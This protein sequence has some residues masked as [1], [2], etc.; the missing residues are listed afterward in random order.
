MSFRLLS[1]ILTGFL[2]S[3]AL[4]LGSG[5][6]WEAL[7]SFATAPGFIAPISVPSDVVGGSVSIDDTPQFVAITPDG[8]RALVANVDDG[9]VSVLDVTPPTI[10]LNSTVTVGTDPICIAITPDGERALVTNSGDNTVTVLELTPTTVVPVDTVSV[11]SLPNGVAITPDGHTALV[12]NRG[13]GTV[14]VLELGSTVQARYSLS[15]GGSSTGA[16]T[17]AITPDGTKALVSLLLDASVSVLDLTQPTFRL[18]YTIPVGDC[19]SG[20]AITHDGTKALVVNNCDGTVSVLDLT[21]STIGPGYTVNVGLSPEDVAITPDGARAYVTNAVADT[22]SVLDVT[23][24]PVSPIHAAI[25][26]PTS[27]FGVAI[28]P[29]QAPTSLFTTSLRGLTVTFD[30]SSS[31]SPVGNVREYIW[32]FGDGSDPV[33]TTSSE[34][35]HTYTGSGVYTASLTVVNDAGTSLETT[36]TGRTASNHGLPRAQSEQ[37]VTL[38][39]LA[40]LSFTGKVHLDK[41]GQRVY[42]ETDWR[43]STDMST[44]RYEIFAYGAKIAVVDANAGDHATIELHPHHFPRKISDTYRR[45]LGNKY[46]VRGVTTDGVASSLV[47]LHVGH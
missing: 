11:G 9:T 16:Y 45:Y 14:T 25:S 19:P 30:G 5:T 23:Q 17:V 47:P 6:T 26:V 10:S 46:A 36:F 43:P 7:V 41:G 28:T 42:L 31:S 40:P 29:D 15:V 37:T 39:P 8:T 1:S 33:T 44:W 27:P 3:S 22:V 18:A 35:S 13:S 12:V 24:T 34:V 32:S 4:L 2:I 38:D 20:I 21:E